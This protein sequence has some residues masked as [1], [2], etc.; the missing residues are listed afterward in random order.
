MAR[1][2]LEDSHLTIP[3]EPERLSTP[4]TPGAIQVAGGKLIVLGVACGTMGGYPHVG[5]VIAPDLSRLAQARPGDRIRFSW[6]DVTDARA[7]ADRDRL[8]YTR[9]IRL[10]ATA[11]RDA[12]GG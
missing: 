4:V 5:H 6:I 8:Q 10:I 1:I 11:A 12:I 7:L 3:A 9:V 2:R